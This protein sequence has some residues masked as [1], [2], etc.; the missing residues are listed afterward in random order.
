MAAPT[1]TFVRHRDEPATRWLE[2][3]HVN[4]GRGERLASLA[5][6]V[7][8]AAFGISRGSATGYALAALGG[9]L[10]Y[11]GA[12]GYCPGYQSLGISSAESDNEAVI[13]S[14]Q[15][16]QVDESVTI[17]RSPE[18]LYRHWRN[19]RNLPRIMRHLVSVEERG[20]GR[21]HWVAQ[22]PTGNVEWDAEIIKDE[23]NELISWK[24]LEDSQ[25][26]TTGSVHF[27]PAPGNRGTEV[28]VVLRYNPPAGRLG[29]AVAWLAGKDP[30]AQIRED[31][32]SL[33][34]VMEAGG[35]PTTEGQPQG[36]CAY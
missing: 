26:A 27:Q 2:G 30:K 1:A 12:T 16:V 23:P 35:V 8:L 24:S 3:R 29:A 18:E 34:Q 17:Q 4:V 6:G 19:F 32:R 21:S 25:V 13:P 36:R 31:L 5:G 9:A 22:G 10:A 14:G 15:G 20:N 7:A 33:K 28:R 11:R